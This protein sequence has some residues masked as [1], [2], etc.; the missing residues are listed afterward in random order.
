[1]G[2]ATV[3]TDARGHYQVELPEGVYQFSTQA[4]TEPTVYF[5][6]EDDPAVT[7]TAGSNLRLDLTLKEHD[8][9]SGTVLEPSGAPSPLAVVV[10]S[11]PGSSPST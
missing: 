10:P 7:V 9:I 2:A 1:M 8:A 11:S 3:E 4:R 5:H 6:V